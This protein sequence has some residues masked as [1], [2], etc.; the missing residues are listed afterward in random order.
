MDD[1]ELMTNLLKIAPLAILIILVFVG[2]FWGL[3]RK[4]DSTHNRA[5]GGG[6]SNWDHWT[7]GH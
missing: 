3:G 1:T 2:V 4:R 5:K 7:G 6:L